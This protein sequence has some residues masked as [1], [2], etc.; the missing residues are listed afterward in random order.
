MAAV[1][2]EVGVVRGHE[3]HGA[4]QRVLAADEAERALGHHVHQIGTEAVQEMR[5][6]AWP[7]EREA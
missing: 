1:L 3:R 4:A 5:D 6:A 2:W 7:G